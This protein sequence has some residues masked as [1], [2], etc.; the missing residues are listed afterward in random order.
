[1]SRV[2]IVG[3]GPAGIRAAETLAGAGLHPVVVDEAARAGGQIY[4]GAIPGQAGG[5]ITYFVVATDLAGNTV[6]GPSQS[7]DVGALFTDGFESG[8]TSMWTV[9]VP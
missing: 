8:D 9:T 2:L 5:T 7:F 6:T 4:R 1:M 3:A